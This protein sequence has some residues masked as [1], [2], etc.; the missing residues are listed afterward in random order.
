MFAVLVEFGMTVK[1]VVIVESQP[2]AFEMWVMYVPVVVCAEP[3]GGVY[4]LPL[5]IEMFA[6]LL[7]F[8]MTVKFVVM[9][10]S[11][12]AAFGICVT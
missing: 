11:Q 9:V 2:A 5:Q 6:E 8:G 4:E 7:E 12:P 1:F 3:P 10:E